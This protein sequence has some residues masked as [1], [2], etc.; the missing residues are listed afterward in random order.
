MN[1]LLSTIVALYN[2]TNSCDIAWM[3][4][5]VLDYFELHKNHT[6]VLE[7]EEVKSKS[8]QLPSLRPSDC[9]W[10]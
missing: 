2:S 3:K 10:L 1:S 4:C 7:N 8:I 9:N 6:M 5:L